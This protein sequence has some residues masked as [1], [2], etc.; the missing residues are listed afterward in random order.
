MKP[1]AL[2]C[3]WH[4]RSC[5]ISALDGG[6]DAVLPTLLQLGSQCPKTLPSQ[7]LKVMVPMQHCCSRSLAQTPTWTSY[8]TMKP[9][10]GDEYLELNDH[11]GS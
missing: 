9:C 11:F 10:L 7:N 6:S 8:P 1:A 4:T 5:L 3:L 2:P